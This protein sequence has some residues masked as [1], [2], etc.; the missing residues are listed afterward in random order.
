[1]ICIIIRVLIILLIGGIW[2]VIMENRESNAI[3]PVGESYNINSHDMHLYSAGEGDNTLVFIAGSGTP[4]S[5]TDFY[6]LQNELQQHLKTVSFDHAG[7]GWSK[8]THSPRTIDS[9]VK[10]LHELLEKSNQSPPYILVA[11]SLASLE[12]LRFAQQYPKE[13]KGI[14]LLDGGSP[15]FFVNY[16][17]TQAYLLNRLAAAL[18]VTGVNRALGSLGFKLPFVGENLRSGSLP[19]EIIHMD[20]SMYYNHI[21]DN[22][23]LNVIKN[24]NENAQIVFDKGHIRNIPLLIL[25][26]D[27]G[28]EWEK[29]QLEFL[30]WSNNSSQKTITCSAHYLHWSH[31]EVVISE[32]IEFLALEEAK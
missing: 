8:R 1:M 3:K 25:S 20:A 23:N 24:I 13:V 4:S 11:H 27:N 22:S 5:F 29:S 7:Y 15:E 16:S 6:Y 17:E 10:E 18:R 30:N 14:V 31:K 9:L 19:H 32:I 21:G 12:A 2:Q 26:S 28:E